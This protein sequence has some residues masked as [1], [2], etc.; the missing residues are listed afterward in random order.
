[1][2]KLSGFVLSV[3]TVCVIA[4]VATGLSPE[5]AMKR[6]I[7]YI[8]SLCVLAAIMTPVICV[9]SSLPSY[10]EAIPELFGGG[11]AARDDAEEKL[12]ETQKKA[13][14]QSIKNV[15]SERFGIDSGSITV[16]ITIDATNKS[17]IEIRGINITVGAKCR[18]EEI[19]AYIDEMFYGTAR[20]IVTEA[21][22]G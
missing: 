7:K 11:E 3:M 17:A 16:E 19:R 13:V 12:I 4:G 15:I 5:G 18:A 10:G 21:F 6:Y 1:M 20:V 14:E 8:V 9:F 2:E 22:D